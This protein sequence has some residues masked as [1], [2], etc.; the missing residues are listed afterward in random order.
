M[1]N[2]F[3]RLLLFVPLMVAYLIAM[4]VCVVWVGI[5][6]LFTGVARVSAVWPDMS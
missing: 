6:W 4:I 2:V 5:G 3:L 1:I